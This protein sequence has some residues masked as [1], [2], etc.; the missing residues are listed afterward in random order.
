MGFFAGFINYFGWIFDLAS[1]ISIPA[2]VV[3]QM[4]AIFHPDLVIEP[5]HIYIAYVLIT[6][7]CCFIVIFGNR[8]LPAINHF[9]LF[10]II[11]GGII[12]II[13]CAVMATHADR[14]F[15]WS[16]FE[17]NNVTG[18][19]S[20]IAFLTGVLNGAF[21]IGTPDAVTKMSEE[22]PNPRRDMP[23]AVLIQVGLGTLTAF[24]YAIAILYSITDLGAVVNSNG[25]FPMAV[26]YSQATGSAAGTFGL[27]LILF[28]SIIVCAID[29][30]LTV[31]FQPLFFSF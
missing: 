26:I 22:L 7:S 25:S 29:T 11:A 23:K 28:L 18:W 27:L 24:V 9:G 13:V 5:W 16:S 10:M 2:N 21:T 12:T 6:W 8:L 4:Y 19:P 14:S 17:E 1:I 15:V 3:V 31:L 20:G 30:Y